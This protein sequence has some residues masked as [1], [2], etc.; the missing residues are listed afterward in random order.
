MPAAIRRFAPDPF[1][2]SLFAAIL[3]ASFLPARGDMAQIVDGFT[4]AAIVL[5]FFLHGVRLERSAVIAALTHWPLH[6]VILGATFVLFPLLGLG[7][8]V[9]LH[10]AMPDA[11]WLGV[12][13]LCAL[14]ST[15]QSSI[16]FTSI[17]RGNVAGAV[18]AAA[19]S[20]ILGV[21][22]APIIVGLI[23]SAHGIV[24][25]GGIAKIGGELIAPFAFGHLLRP[26]LGQWAARN[27][28]LLVFT[29]RGTIVLAVY[30]AFSVAVNDHIW[31]Q[32]P[33]A[34]LLI[35]VVICALLLA[36]VLAA[37]RYGSRALG[38]SREDEIAILFCGSKK[39]LAS[40]LPM[41]RVLFTGAT[42][43]PVMLPLILFHQ[44]QLITCAWIARRYAA[45]TEG[46]AA[47]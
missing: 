8:R 30:S 40:G 4:T 20:N 46:P 15:V 16:A 23:S 22:L 38:F 2:L 43:G 27:R 32:I 44:I 1:I 35:L 5:L 24:S 26:W 41:A 34:T 33:P 19:T 29:D 12:L 9:L 47:N 17:A 25:P 31:S 37:T 36:L 18:A 45:S 10:P 11:L 28:R 14:P 6:L 13:F 42:I 3:V 21:A 39:S 7:L